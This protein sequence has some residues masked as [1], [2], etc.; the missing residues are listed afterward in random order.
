MESVATT[1]VWIGL[2]YAGVG[3][4]AGVAFVALGVDRIDP[5]AKGSG[6]GFRMM[7]LPGAAALWPWTLRAWRSSGPIRSA[8]GTH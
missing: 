2:A 7:I 8:E 4:A 6:W 1:I 5:A 3:L